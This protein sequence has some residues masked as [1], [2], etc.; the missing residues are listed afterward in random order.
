MEKV[1]TKRIADF[2]SQEEP[3]L[4][5]EEPGLYSS[6]ELKN[7]TGHQVLKPN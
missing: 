5:Q 7:V 3:A 1:C 6:S 2:R 4:E